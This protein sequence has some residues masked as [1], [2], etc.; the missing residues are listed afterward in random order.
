MPSPQLEQAMEIWRR[1]AT[2]L[3]GKGV[4]ESRLGFLEIW[5]SFTRPPSDVTYRP[6]AA[7]GVK[8]EWVIPPQ[9]AEGKAIL[10]FHGGG[11][12]FCSPDTHRELVAHLAKAAGIQALLLDYRLAPEFPFPGAV[13]DAVA[14]Y[15][16][17]LSQG[18]RPEGVG[19]AGD[20]AGGGLAVA[21]MVAFRY[22]GLPMPG[23]SVCFSPWTDLACTGASMET[24]A[25]E[26]PIV[27][28]LLLQALAAIYLQGADPTTPL[29]SPLYADLRGLPPLLVQVGTAETLLDDSRRL[30]E[31]CREAGVEVQLDEWEG[32]PHVWHFFVSFLPEAQEAIAKAG[33]FLRRHL[34]A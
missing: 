30:A 34:K 14:A 1:T 28:K 17:L 5:L 32:M 3:A 20:S 10:Y 24:K 4:W 2:S 7:G 27:S 31:R 25:K 12:V 33:E 29:A 6:V 11:Y 15:R 21:A 16:W 26:D 23:A 22:L 13:E 18:Y 8:A 19:L 9:A